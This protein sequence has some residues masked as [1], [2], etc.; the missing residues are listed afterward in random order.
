MD[1]FLIR[2]AIAL[3]ASPSGSDE[4]RPL[5]PKGRRRFAQSVDGLAHLGLSF[6]LLLHSPWL[7]AL[8]TA[9]LLAGLVRGETRV[10]P[11]LAEPPGRPLLAELT[12]AGAAPVDTKGRLARAPRRVAAVGHEPWLSELAAWLV[13][14][15]PEA[16]RQLNLGKGGVLWLRGEPAPGEMKLHALLT[17]KLV[18]SLA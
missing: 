3:D 11:G 5:S 7:R 14:E 1:L 18:R 4:A 9:E 10:T 15:D 8:E 17:P 2:H 16:G 6:D 13:L 12:G